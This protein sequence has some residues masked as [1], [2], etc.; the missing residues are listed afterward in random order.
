MFCTWK[1]MAGLALT[2][3]GVIGHTV[4]LPFCDLT[5]I[6]CN[7][8]SAILINMWISSKY[9]GEKFIAKYDVSAAG[10]VSLGTL[11]IIL[12]SNKEQQTFPV[13]RLLGLL[14]SLQS[15]LYFA[16]TLAGMATLRFWMPLF[17]RKVREFESDCE[18]WDKRHPDQKIL[19]DKVKATDDD[20]IDADRADRTL[21]SIIN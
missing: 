7:S 4:A 13:D 6:A 8:S 15:L 10:L 20:V 5:L 11:A 3:V 18:K 1:G 2:I 16:I 21:I 19:P 17:L 9:L 12:M 14:T